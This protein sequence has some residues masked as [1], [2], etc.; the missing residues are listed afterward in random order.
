MVWVVGPFDHLYVYPAV[1][2]DGFAVAE[3]FESSHFA[4]TFAIVTV[5]FG[6]LIIV[7]DPIAVH[8]FWSVTVTE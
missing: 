3:P 1:P 6:K 2:P 5:G 4:S 7:I 8:P